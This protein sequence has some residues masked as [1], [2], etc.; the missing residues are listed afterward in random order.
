MPVRPETTF[1]CTECKRPIADDIVEQ[2]A[3]ALFDQES[4]LTS[5]QAVSYVWMAPRR[6]AASS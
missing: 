5:F 4:S 3:S 1:Q 6:H 2:L